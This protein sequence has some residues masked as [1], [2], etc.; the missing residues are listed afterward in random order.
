MAIVSACG[1]QYTRDINGIMMSPEPDPENPLTIPPRLTANTENANAG[2]RITSKRSGTT[3]NKQRFGAYGL[4]R[5]EQH[6]FP[7]CGSFPQSSQPVLD[8]GMA[9]PFDR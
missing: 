2:V 6:M 5:F 8:G 4:A 7:E 9:G 1:G 3:V